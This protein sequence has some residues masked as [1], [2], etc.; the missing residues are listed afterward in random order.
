[1]FVYEIMLLTPSYFYFLLLFVLFS[2]AKFYGFNNFLGPTAFSSLFFFSPIIWSLPY[3]ESIDLIITFFMVISYFLFFKLGVS[4]DPSFIL[5]KFI[6]YN[7]GYYIFISYILISTYFFLLQI[8]IVYFGVN[9]HVDKL[10]WTVSSGG[11]SYL[12]S[13]VEMSV[14]VIAFYF[15]ELKKYFLFFL[16]ASLLVWG[17]VVFHSKSVLLSFI[18]IYLINKSRFGIEFKYITRYIIIISIFFTLTSVLFFGGLNADSYTAFA[19]RVF[20]T[21]DGTF[22]IL[23]SGMYP[24]Y[25]LPHSSLYYIF[26]LFTSKIYGVTESVGQIVAGYSNTS[27]PKFGG[28]N[29][30][31]VN[32]LFL[33]QGL[34]KLNVVIFV[35]ALSFISGSLDK[36]I[37]SER[38][39][40]SLLEFKLIIYPLYL[41]I[42]SFFQATGTAFMLL[43]RLYIFLIPIVIFIFLV[44]KV[45][46]GR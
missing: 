35:C 1:M 31:L 12:F 11:V 21:I 37:K 29:D 2:F 15:I 24:D 38:C 23:T 16:V 5:K 32:Y 20:A 26:D 6:G 19:S 22:T 41:F 34:D 36:I 33:T 18:V 3:L 40:F 13:A 4:I 43:A 46:Y 27:Y 30:S 44:R 39:T 25:S 42:P 14:I 28:P 7:K 8:V 9:G 10:A 45:F 17:G